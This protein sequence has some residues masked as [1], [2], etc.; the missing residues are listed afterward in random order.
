MSA[1]LRCGVCPGLTQPMATGDALLARITPAGATISCDA[2]RALCAAA[3][4]CGNGVMEVTSRGSV[5]IR[6]LME[7][8]PKRLAAVLGTIEMA[9]C[10]GHPILN[11]PQ[12]GA[13]PDEALATAIMPAS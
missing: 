6:G 7:T 13:V 9:F 10:K 12:P 5:Q 4:R 11:K 2:F 3:R 8:S 1:P